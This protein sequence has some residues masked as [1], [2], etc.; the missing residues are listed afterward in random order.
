M[1]VLVLYVLRQGPHSIVQVVTPH[2]VANTSDTRLQQ[3]SCPSLSSSGTTCHL[4]QWYPD[5]SA[6]FSLMRKT[7]SWNVII[8][9]W[10]GCCLI[11]LSAVLMLPWKAAR[12]RTYYLSITQ[13]KVRKAPILQGL[14][15]F[16]NCW[17]IFFSPVVCLPI[18]SSGAHKEPL[19]DLL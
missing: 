10:H 3:S 17:G 13:E 6:W 19:T 4:I 7:I 2:C 8:W 1:L 9:E 16:N 18:I 14:W 15:T 11:E 12:D 5:L